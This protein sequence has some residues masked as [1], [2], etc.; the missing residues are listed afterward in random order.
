MHLDPTSTATDDSVTRARALSQP[1]GIKK[2]GGDF[3]R[4]SAVVRGLF[5]GQYDEVGVCHLTY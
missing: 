2:R 5:D 4:L 1:V 3:H